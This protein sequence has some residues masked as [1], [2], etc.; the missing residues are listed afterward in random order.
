MDTTKIKKWLF[1]LKKQVIGVTSDLDSF[2]YIDISK[3]VEIPIK[4]HVGAFGI[5][6]RHDTQKGV[7][8]YSDIDAPVYAVED[9]IV[10]L[11]R[12]FT[13]KDAGCDWWLDTQALNVAGESGIVVYGEIEVSKELFMGKEI[14]QGDVVGVVKRVL[15]HDKGRPTSMLHIALHNHGIQSNGLWEKGTPQPKGLIDPTPFLIQ[16]IK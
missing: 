10:C 9:G 2:K 6:R 5:E 14:K 11:I 8:L 3:Q 15:K 13:G 12:P 1:P 7:D 4:P 16:S